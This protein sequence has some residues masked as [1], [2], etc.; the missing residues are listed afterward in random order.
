M[1]LECEVREG[2]F[3]L[4]M[5]L[6][7]ERWPVLLPGDP[8]RAID[9]GYGRYDAVTA[10]LLAGFSTK[11]AERALRKAEIQESGRAP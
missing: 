3:F 4:F 2:R 11:Q 1:K 5:R 9:V 7:R 8:P 10:A 6:G